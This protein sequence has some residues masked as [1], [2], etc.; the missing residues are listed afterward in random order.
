MTTAVSGVA[1]LEALRTQSFDVIISDLNMPERGGLWL[2]RQA[3][4][5]RPELRG[6]FVLIASEPLP[7]PRTMSLF[8]ESERFLLKPLT[9]DAL[10]REVES[11]IHAARTA[12]PGAR[13]E[14]RQHPRRSADRA[15]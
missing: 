14:R 6:R 8:L 9:L 4:V 10:W 7:E 11:V 2:W 3:L 13:V 12:E 15:M 1:G 5:L